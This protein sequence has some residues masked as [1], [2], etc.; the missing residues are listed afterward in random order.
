MIIHSLRLSCTPEEID[1]C[2]VFHD[3]LHNDYMDVRGS[4]VLLSG[5]LGWWGGLVGPG[6]KNTVLTLDQIDGSN[7]VVD[8]EG[9]QLDATKGC[10]HGLP[11]S[12]SIE[13]AEEDDSEDNICEFIVHKWTTADDPGNKVLGVSIEL[14]EHICERTTRKCYIV[15]PGRRIT[16]RPP[17]Q[18]LMTFGNPLKENQKVWMKVAV[19]ERFTV[20][21]N[22]GWRKLI[23]G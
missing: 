3:F 9:G 16:S 18:Y 5:Y 7:V 4:G 13:L 22:K 8:L 10:F 1:E 11:C 23:D 2:S 20:C 21:T 15:G 17:L 6:V 14:T 12:N 19:W